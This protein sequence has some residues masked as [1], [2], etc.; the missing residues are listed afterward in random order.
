MA[1]GSFLPATDFAALGGMKTPD[2]KKS[3]DSNLK[4]IKISTKKPIIAR[5]P[6][7]DQQD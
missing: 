2:L 7:L 3:N 4:K 5:K 1:G 6:K